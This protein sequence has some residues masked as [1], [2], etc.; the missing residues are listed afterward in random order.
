[1]SG[2]ARVIASADHGAELL[3]G[4]VLVTTLTTPDWVPIMRRAAAIVTETGGMTSHAAIVS[5]ELGLP[6]V[7]GARDATH[8]LRTGLAITVDARAGVVSQGATRAEAS[9]LRQR[10]SLRHG[11]T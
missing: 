10:Q 1:V 6:C 11:S 3:P 9:S 4:E 8:V 7:V 5:R 2:V